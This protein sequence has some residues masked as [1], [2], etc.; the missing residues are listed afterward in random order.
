[1]S[2]PPSPVAPAHP[3]LAFRN[4]S[5]KL[6]E[7]QVGA[8]KPCKVDRKPRFANA[9]RL[10][11]KSTSLAA[12]KTLAERQSDSLL[13]ATE[14]ELISIDP[15][16]TLPCRL[17]RSGQDLAHS[18]KSL[19]LQHAP[20]WPSILCTKTAGLPLAYT[21]KANFLQYARK[22]RQ[23]PGYSVRS[24]TLLANSPIGLSTHK[25][26]QTRTL[27]SGDPGRRRGIDRCFLAP[28]QRYTG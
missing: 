6:A 23:V 2:S 5:G 8:Q 12:D 28:G 3:G 21:H 1:M 15:F 4:P 22:R 25:L 17:D 19:F 13:A 11:P 7:A 10:P 27:E 24:R 20:N 26:C 14:R 16:H 18:A 9:Q